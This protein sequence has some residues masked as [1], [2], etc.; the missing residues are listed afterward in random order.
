M[1]ILKLFK[2]SKSQRDYKCC[3]DKSVEVV[4]PKDK[5]RRCQIPNHLTNLSD[6]KP[7]NLRLYQ[8]FLN[9]YRY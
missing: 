7:Q 6:Y 9:L 4:L 8:D 1:H 3:L 2:L 5:T